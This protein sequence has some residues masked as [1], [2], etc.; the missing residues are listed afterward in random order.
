MRMVLDG[1]S[2][3]VY[4]VTLRLSYFS[5]VLKAHSEYRRLRRGTDAESVLEYLMNIKG[6][7]PEIKGMSK[8]WM[9]PRALLGLRI[10]M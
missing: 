7:M 4:L 10:R 2:A 9:I 8:G 1:C 3:A 5:A 6:E